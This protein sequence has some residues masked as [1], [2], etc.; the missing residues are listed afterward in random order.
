M[1]LMYSDELYLSLFL[2]DN[3]LVKFSFHE[4]IPIIIMIKQIIKYKN[5]GLFILEED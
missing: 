4:E 3:L 5:I 1:R 2:Y